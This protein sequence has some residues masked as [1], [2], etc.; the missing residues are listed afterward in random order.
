LRIQRN[1]LVKADSEDGEQKNRRL[2]VT[3]ESTVRSTNRVVLTIAIEWAQFWA[4]SMFRA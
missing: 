3:L 1:F 4:Q 2:H